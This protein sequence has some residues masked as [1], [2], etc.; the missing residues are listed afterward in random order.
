M[1]EQVAEA[2]E[3]GIETAC[4]PAATMMMIPTTVVP[5]TRPTTTAETKTATT[6]TRRITIDKCNHPS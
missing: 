4:C 1:L 2:R 6:K 3:E 5:A